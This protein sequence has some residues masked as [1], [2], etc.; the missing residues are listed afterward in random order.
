[1]TVNTPEQYRRFDPFADE[2]PACV[3]RNEIIRKT[4]ESTDQWHA[5][6]HTLRKKMWDQAAR[7]EL[8]HPFRDAAALPDGEYAVFGALMIASAV[9]LALEDEGK[10]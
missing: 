8:V 3:N 7:G 10:F 4:C 5:T 9:L 2:L 1:M 6:I